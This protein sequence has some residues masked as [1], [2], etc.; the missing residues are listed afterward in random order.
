MQYTTTLYVHSSQI[1]KG[2]LTSDADPPAD[3]SWK[4]IFFVLNTYVCYNE[5]SGENA[6]CCLLL[7][8]SQATEIPKTLH[9]SFLLLLILIH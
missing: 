2:D 8:L 9:C 4:Q 5:G 3:T 1:S 7:H 6:S